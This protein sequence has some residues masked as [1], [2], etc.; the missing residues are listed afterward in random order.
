MHLTIQFV[1]STASI[2]YTSF[3]ALVLMRAF[4]EPLAEMC[5]LLQRH[6]IF[7][8]TPFLWP[9]S[10]RLQPS[11]LILMMAQSTFTFLITS[12]IVKSVLLY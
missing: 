5:A 6:T 9:F 4:L 3:F 7:L 11:T 2:D 10:W 12:H 8:A 1:H